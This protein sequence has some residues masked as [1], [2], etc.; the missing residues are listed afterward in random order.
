[1][2]IVL[3]GPQGAGKGTCAQGLKDELDAQVFES[4]RELRKIAKNDSGLGR[5]LKGVL[6]SGGLV[7]DGHIYF[8]TKDWLNTVPVGEN[9]ILDGCP[10]KLTQTKDIEKLLAMRG[11]KID[12]VVVLCISDEVAVGRLLDRLICSGEMEH[13]FNFKSKPPKSEGICDYDGLP[14]IR[15]VDE[16]PV[17]IKARLKNYHQETV[18]VIEYFK[19]RGI[20]TEVDANMPIEAVF[21]EVL[22]RITY[23]FGP[24]ENL[25]SISK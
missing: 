12:F 10:R 5:E 14:L 6:D 20:V 25:S 9:M 3:E 23:R 17:T 7:S 1:M 22:K 18:P 16:T 15:R 8:L 24:L 19:E 11:E 21:N 13:V 2:I 4:G